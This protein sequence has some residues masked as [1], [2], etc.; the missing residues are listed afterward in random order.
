MKNSWPS[1]IVAIAGFSVITYG[2]FLAWK[3]LGFVFGGVVLIFLAY[4]IEKKI[5][6]GT[7]QPK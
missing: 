3:P 7:E 5:S 1:D 6:S 2:A 4:C